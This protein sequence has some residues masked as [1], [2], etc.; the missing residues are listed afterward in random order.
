VRKFKN[1]YSIQP[2]TITP[3][4]ELDF[5]RYNAI[6]DTFVNQGEYNAYT[7]ERGEFRN[8]CKSSIGKIVESI[9][10]QTNRGENEI[11]RNLFFHAV[12]KLEETHV[13]NTRQILSPI[14]KRLI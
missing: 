13:I 6:R 5:E 10:A 14:I 11:Y 2:L 12:E 7:K 8:K 3:P 9:Q 1:I 4:T